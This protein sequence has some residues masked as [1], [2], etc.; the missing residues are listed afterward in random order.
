MS[1]LKTLLA[2]IE[3]ATGP[4]LATEIALALALKQAPEGFHFV[5]ETQSWQRYVSVRDSVEL[6]VPPPYTASL[7]AVVRLVT[8]L[9]P[10]W[11]WKVGTCHVSDDAWVCPD[12]N[13]PEH[14]A[15]LRDRYFP[16]DYNGP[17]DAGFDID[18]RPPGNLPLALLEA[19]LQ[20]LIAEEAI[21]A[22][23]SEA[24]GD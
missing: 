9:L 7:D 3:K 18:R 12:F 16:I 23:R 22:Q 8:T 11:G 13:D 10:G 6:W 14:G 1:S 5:E 15:R 19:L 2:R 4:N 17:Y 21:P 24:Y 20:A